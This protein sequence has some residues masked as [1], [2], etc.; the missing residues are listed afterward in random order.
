MPCIPSLLGPFLSCSTSAN[1]SD[2]DGAAFDAYR[3]LL[4]WGIPAALAAKRVST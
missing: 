4:L 1:V 2:Q 3:N